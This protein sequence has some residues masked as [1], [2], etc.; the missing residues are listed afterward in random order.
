[1][2]KISSKEMKIILKTN[3][4]AEEYNLTKKFSRTL[5]QQ[6]SPRRKNS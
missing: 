4:R 2:S 3:P 6:T 5:Q 1:M